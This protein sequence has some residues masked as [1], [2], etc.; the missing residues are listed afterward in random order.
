LGVFHHMVC[1]YKN[2]YAKKSNR[3]HLATGFV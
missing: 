3:M 2:I 1:I